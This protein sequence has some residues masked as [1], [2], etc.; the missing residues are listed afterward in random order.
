M[1]SVSQPL[2]FAGIRCPVLLSGPP[3]YSDDASRRARQTQPAV[4]NANAPMVVYLIALCKLIE[5]ARLQ[6]RIWNLPAHGWQIPCPV[7]RRSPVS[8]TVW[9]ASLVLVSETVRYGLSSQ[10]LQN[11]RSNV[12]IV[13][14]L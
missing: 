6:L 14:E 9:L 4:N 8:L 13:T 10:L 11:S 2:K 5:K 3:H 12:N 1:I 7:G